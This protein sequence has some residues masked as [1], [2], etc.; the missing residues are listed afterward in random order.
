ML[1]IE[2]R[3]TE[4]NEVI[5]IQ[6]DG[7]VVKVHEPSTE[8]IR[9]L[10]GFINMNAALMSPEKSFAE[11][12][13]LIC[14]SIGKAL[15]TG[16]LMCVNSSDNPLNGIL[17]PWDLSKK[18]N[19]V[20]GGVDLDWIAYAGDDV[21]RGTM[22]LAESYKDI[23]STRLKYHMV[24]DFPTHACNGHFDKIYIT[25]NS[26]FSDN[27]NGA[28]SL[29]FKLKSY[30]PKIKKPYTYLRNEL[31]NPI[32]VNGSLIGLFN[33]YKDIYIYKDGRVKTFTLEEL[34]LPSSFEYRKLILINNKIYLDDVTNRW[35]DYIKYHRF[36][37]VV[38]E[39][40]ENIKFVET[41]LTF[42]NNFGIRTDENDGLYFNNSSK[43]GEFTLLNLKCVLNDTLQSCVLIIDESLEVVKKMD[44]FSTT[45]F[46]TLERNGVSFFIIDDKVYDKEFNV[47]TTF[48]LPTNP[49]FLTDGKKNIMLGGSGNWPIFNAGRYGVYEIATHDDGIIEIQLQEPL[50]KKN[51]QTLKL[52]FDFDIDLYS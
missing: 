47:V 52:I 8:T 11:I 37:E 21:V 26:K 28:S 31:S 35:N 1:T 30:I 16:N 7:Y 27:S 45:N 29:S 19:G 5:S 12:S 14:P 13:N 34:G 24:L 20:V 6:Q 9:N 3:D 39:D 48:N 50:T 33:S 42:L 46:L 38:F 17:Y 4:T 15:N 23:D 51:T 32:F 40:L 49:Y 2:K 36:W 22:N 43:L 25:A 41:S 44:Y 10:V 18:E